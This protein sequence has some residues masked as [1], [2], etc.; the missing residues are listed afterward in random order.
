MIKSITV[1]NY[2]GESITLELGCPEK[3]GF[4]VQDVS[5]LGPGKATINYTDLAMS[6]GG[7]FNSAR[8]GARNIVLSLRFLENP[9]I[10]LTRQMSYKYFP[11]KSLIKLLIETDTRVC[12]IYG[13]VE[14][15]EPNI[16]SS[17]EGTQISILCPNP[18]FYSLERTITFFSLIEPLFHFELSNESLTENLINLG[19][20]IVKTEQSV[21]YNGDSE[22]GIIAHIHALGS[23]TNLKITDYKTNETMTIDTTKLATLTGSGIIAGDDIVISTIKGQKQIVLL[24]SGVYTNIMNCLDMDTYW[25]QL[26]RG[27]N[28]IGISADTGISNVQF[29]IENQSVYEGV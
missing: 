4:L 19:N 26:S 10:E 6:D 3:S 15:N 8:M 21:I 25:F 7:V 23:V 18:Y 13:Y 9:T 1:T 16:F 5:G 22:I 28:V 24:R 12:E 11:I 17:E 2:V 20:I 29:W 27:D 14:S